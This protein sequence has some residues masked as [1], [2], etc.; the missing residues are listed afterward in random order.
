MSNRNKKRCRIYLQNSYKKEKLSTPL[1]KHEWWQVH[2]T[3]HRQTEHNKP[4]R[5]EDNSCVWEELVKS[6]S[7]VDPVVFFHVKYNNTDASYSA[8]SQSRIGSCLQTYGNWQLEDIWTYCI[9]RRNN[10]KYRAKS[11]SHFFLPLSHDSPYHPF[12]QP[13]GGQCPVNTL[14]GPLKQ[15]QFLVQLLPK[16]HTSHA[17]IANIWVSI[18]YCYFQ[19]T[20]QIRVRYLAQLLKNIAL[21]VHVTMFVYI[22]QFKYSRYEKERVLYNVV[23]EHRFHKFFV[24]FKPSQ[25]NQDAN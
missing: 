10:K 20:I 23:R 1:Q 16:Y 6:T 7:K 4:H 14:Y 13:P 21:H 19:Q 22:I 17:T 15:L 8:T 18:T 24:H 2:K 3:I 12:L 9:T 11:C 25:F 5:I